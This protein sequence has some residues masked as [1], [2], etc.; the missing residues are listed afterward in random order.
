MERNKNVSASVA[1]VW[2]MIIDDNGSFDTGNICV[3]NVCESPL[4]EPKT[5]RTSNA[6]SIVL[7]AATTATRSISRLCSLALVSAKRRSFKSAVKAKETRNSAKRSTALS[8]S[9][10][11]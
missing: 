2:S 6:F 4:D 1:G 5:S 10:A 9:A 11:A 7:S 8:P 3:R